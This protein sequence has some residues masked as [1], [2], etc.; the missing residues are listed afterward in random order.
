MNLQQFRFVRETIRRDFNLT[1]AAKSLYTSQPGVSKAIMEFEQELGVQIFERHGKR[2]KGLTK[3]G[4]AVAEVVERINHEIDNL[5]RVS[6]EYARRDQ[7]RLVIACTHT[8]ARYALPAVI[9]AFREQFPKVKLALAE[10]SPTQLADMLLNGQADLAIA[11]ESLAQT[12]GLASVPC[13]RW[14]HAVVFT[15]DHPL[16]KR[17]D[18]NGT[19]TLAD[20]AEFP[21]VTYDLAFSGRRHIDESFASAGLQPEIVLAAIDADVIKTYVSLGLGIGIIAA[22]A[23]DPK[24][25]QGLQCAPAGHLFGQQTARVAVRQ[26]E[27]LR[28][29]VYTFISM[30]A[31][32]LKPAEIRALIRPNI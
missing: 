32:D 23:H 29:Y 12:P 7:G 14:Q 19:L 13:Y 22:M 21:I 5:K 30:L 8:Q 4:H 1:A 11:T 10:G 27:F 3:P 16:A 9:P 20:L 25:D 28:D 31:P 17:Y 24:Q 26:G 6:D 15:P 2:I 18:A